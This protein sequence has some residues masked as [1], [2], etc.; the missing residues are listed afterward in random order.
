MSKVTGRR[1]HASQKGVVVGDVWIAQLDRK[2]VPHARSS[3]CINSVAVTAECTRH[4]ASRNVSWPQR[5]SDTWQQE[6]RLPGQRLTNQ[7]CHFE[8]DRLS[9]SPL[10]FW[11]HLTLTFDL[12]PL[13]VSAIF[14]IFPWAI[15]PI[16]WK[17]PF[18]T[19]TYPSLFHK[20]NKNEHNWL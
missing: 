10:K 9:V 4:H 1:V 19:V 8:L 3:G 20:S 16:T 11:W 15:L 14:R 17:L 13:T 5:L 2:R 12:W 7:T 18:C 6:R